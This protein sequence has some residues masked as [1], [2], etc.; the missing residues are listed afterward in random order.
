MNLVFMMG[1]IVA[2]VPEDFTAHPDPCPG[3][4]Q[5][6]RMAQKNVLVTSLNAVEAPGLHVICTDKTG[7]LTMNRRPSTRLANRSPGWR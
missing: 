3:D 7:T 1:I 6:A 2:N 5:S 4:G